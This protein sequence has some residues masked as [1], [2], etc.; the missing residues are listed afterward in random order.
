MILTY[1][2][3][4]IYMMAMIMIL[5]NH[6]HHINHLKIIGQNHSWFLPR[7]SPPV[8]PTFVLLKKIKVMELL[9]ELHE[10]T[11]KILRKA[12]GEWQMLSH[13]Q[14]SALPAP[15]AWSAAQCLEHL[16][17]YGRH[18][19]PAIEKAIQSGK[20][21]G[22]R[23]ARAFKSGWLGAYFTQLMLPK[24]D[25]ALKSKMKAPKNAVPAAQPDPQAMLAEFIDQ[26]ETM[27]RLL[28]QAESVNL[29]TLR[30]PISL[31][32]WIRLKLGDTFGFVIAHMERHVL[33]IDSS[34]V[35]FE[36]TSI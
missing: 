18:Y 21:A 36:D 15:G 17:I 26:Q 35:V 25:G 27:L 10:R 9:E 5:C 24:A 19:L 34:I 32:P 2:F 6:G 31:S 22:S 29:N 3:K 30:V 13:E 4:V 7:I 16:N 12:V 28:R 8:L 33:Q 14:M 1:D 11:E 20:Q 23:P